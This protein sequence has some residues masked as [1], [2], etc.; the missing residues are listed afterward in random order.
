MRI[1]GLEANLLLTAFDAYVG[2]DGDGKV[3]SGKDGYSARY[4]QALRDRLF[5]AHEHP[6]EEDQP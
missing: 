5:E 1:T 3:L 6:D 2:I 4:L